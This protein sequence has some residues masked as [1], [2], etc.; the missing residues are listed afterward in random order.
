[1]DRNQIEEMGK[2]ELRQACRDAAISY[3]KL[4]NAGMKAALKA[5][6]KVEAG[7]TG[8]SQVLADE[9]GD[10]DPTDAEIDESNEEGQAPIAANP[11]GALMGNVTIPDA[12]GTSTKVVDG[13]RVDPETATE[14]KPHQPRPRVAKTPAPV[15]P[16]VIRKGYKIQ[17]ERPVQ[18]GVKRPSEGTVCNKV[19]LEFDAKPEITAAE[20]AE[21]ADKNGWNR[22]NVSCEFY[23]WRKFNGIKGRQ[24]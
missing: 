23:A 6:Y 13:K 18:N 7:Q 2:N 9:I 20:L 16:K 4:N 19:W 12:V 10:G 17:K 22:T 11:F 21:L 3:G 24:Q 8:A 1:M 14:T 5:H 15:V